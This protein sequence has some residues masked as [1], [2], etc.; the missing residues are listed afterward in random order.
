M[1][2]DGNENQT[3]LSGN[4]RVALVEFYQTLIYLPDNVT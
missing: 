3:T 2:D 4:N 1:I